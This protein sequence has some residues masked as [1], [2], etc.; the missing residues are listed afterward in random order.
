MGRSAVN[1]KA[2]PIKSIQQKA[3]SFFLALTILF[4]WQL[5]HAWRGDHFSRSALAGIFAD[6]Q[7]II[8]T[9]ELNEEEVEF[10]DA[11]V[12][13]WQIIWLPM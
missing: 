10:L 11:L 2:S 8:G 5:I 1:C 9:D 6:V 7:S 12:S 4:F 3:T 13:V